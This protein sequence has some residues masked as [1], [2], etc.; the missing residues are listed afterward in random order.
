MAASLHYCTTHHRHHDAHVS[1]RCLSSPRSRAVAA[2][3]LRPVLLLLPLAALLFPLVAAA[4]AAR[5]ARACS[6]TRRTV[7]AGPQEML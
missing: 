7:H 2:A 6:P 3:V 5:T 4:A 1:L